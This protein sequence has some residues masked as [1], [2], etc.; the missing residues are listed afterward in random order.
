HA[1]RVAGD[2]ELTQDTTRT[3]E[4]FAAR[5]DEAV[6]APDLPPDIALLARWWEGV[7]QRRPNEIDRAAVVAAADGDPPVAWANH[8]LGREALRSDADDDASARFAREA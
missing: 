1:A 3:P 7:V 2:R 6:G 8:L 5:V 4:A